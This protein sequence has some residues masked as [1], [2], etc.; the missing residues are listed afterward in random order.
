M[1]STTAN[2]AIK[3]VVLSLTLQKKKK[4]SVQLNIHE[5]KDQGFES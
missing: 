2:F 1:P 4:R 5:P 3:N